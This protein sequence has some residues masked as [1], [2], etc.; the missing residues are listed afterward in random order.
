M[1]AAAAARPPDK[2]ATAVYGVL[3]GVGGRADALAEAVLAR[4]FGSEAYG[5]ANRRRRAATASG[6]GAGRDV[7]AVG[8]GAF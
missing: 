6:V 4:V 7:A 5:A 3:G 2:G 8:A 1:A